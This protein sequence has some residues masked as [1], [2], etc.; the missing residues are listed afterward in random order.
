MRFKWENPVFLGLLMAVAA[1]VVSCSKDS[2]SP[3]PTAV[4]RGEPRLAQQKLLDLQD[5][6][7]WT[8]K[9][10]TDALAHIYSKLSHGKAGSSKAEKCRGGVAALKEFNKSFSK[11]GKSKGVADDFL[12]TEDV[13]SGNSLAGVQTQIGTPPGL[14]SKAAAMLRQIPDLFDSG[15]SGATIVSRVTAIENDATGS[16]SAAEAAAVVSLG[17]VAISSAQYWNANLPSWRSAQVSGRTA[18]DQ[19][20]TT[21]RGSMNLANPAANTPRSSTSGGASIG[22]ADAFAFFTSLFAGWWMGVM[23]IEVS[24]I[25][26]VIASMLAAF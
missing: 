9:Y 17:S 4:V 5:R 16:L 10:H 24:A 6:Y 1:T 18:S 14:S 13:C 15:A 26:A 21:I 11:D 2:T 25:R 20:P 8:G 23:D 22:K 3:A 12:T 19:L 7:G